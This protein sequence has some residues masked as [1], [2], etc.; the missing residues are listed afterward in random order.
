MAGSATFTMVVSRLTRNA[1]SSSAARIMGLD[2]I[3]SPPTWVVMPRSP[4][5]RAGPSAAGYRSAALVLSPRPATHR[6]G[7]RC[8]A[9]RPF[10]ARLFEERYEFGPP[11]VVTQKCLPGGISRRGGPSPEGVTGPALQG[12]PA[13]P[14]GR[15]SA[16]AQARSDHGASLRLGWCPAGARRSGR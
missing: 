3:G 11:W 6:V 7:R 9:P 8:R 1:A 5:A 13:G 2:R 10:K 16:A 15:A 12:L 4:G 14:D